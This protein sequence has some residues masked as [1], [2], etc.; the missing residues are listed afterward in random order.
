MITS[1]FSITSVI[2][3]RQVT[4]LPSSSF[5]CSRVGCLQISLLFYILTPFLGWKRLLLADTPRQAINALTLYAVWLVKKK[6]TGPWY[7]IT[8][9]FKG[10]SLSTS[11]LTVTS[12]FTVAVC[13]GSL[14][15]LVIAGI[16]YVPLLIHI[17]GNLKVIDPC[18]PSRIAF[19]HTIDYCRNTAATRLTR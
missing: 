16:C 17:R 1:A 13:A 10:N 6:N 18:T 5:S 3:P 9:Y 2:R 7:D 8:K 15:L 4:T 11:A 14:L 12:F 19:S